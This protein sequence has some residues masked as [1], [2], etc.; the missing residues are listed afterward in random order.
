MSSVPPPPAAWTNRLLPSKVVE[1]RQK[2]YEKRVL[3]KIQEE[4]LE[5]LPPC[6]DLPSV[7]VLTTLS[8]T[9][10]VLSN[11]PGGHLKH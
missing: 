2:N 4:T 8:S 3:K 1:K 10:T 9:F 11:L 5:K 6:E 7:K